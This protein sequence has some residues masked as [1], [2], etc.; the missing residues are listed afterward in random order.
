MGKKP[1]LEDFLTDDLKKTINTFIDDLGLSKPTK[2]ALRTHLFEK[3][4][5]CSTTG[6]PSK[7]HLESYTQNWANQTLSQRH[8]KS[9]VYP[10]VFGVLAFSISLSI[11]GQC[12]SN[13]TS[14]ASPEAWLIAVCVALVV[15]AAVAIPLTVTQKNNT[16]LF[17]GETQLVRSDD[18]L[19]K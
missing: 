11:T 19:P 6:V 8:I 5:D 16:Q 14:L 10:V 9:I 13:L 15:T 1:N 3:Q 18:Y 7:N 17:R 12:L 2:A 4:L